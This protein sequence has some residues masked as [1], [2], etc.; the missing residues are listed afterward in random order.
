M[1]VLALP[2]ACSAA[3]L[4]CSFIGF[5]PVIAA[6]CLPAVVGGCWVFA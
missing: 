5:R 3:V 2:F 1:T 6:C 4:A